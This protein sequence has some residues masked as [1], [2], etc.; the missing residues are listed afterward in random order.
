MLI[1][2][3][4][5]L[6]D[7]LK[8]TLGIIYRLLKTNVYCVTLLNEWLNEEVTNQY[9]SHINSLTFLWLQNDITENISISLASNMC[10]VVSHSYPGLL[11][12]EAHEK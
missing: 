1:E 10:E 7:N 2:N 6:T 12:S 11:Y 3:P 5:F 8:F 9:L 4:K